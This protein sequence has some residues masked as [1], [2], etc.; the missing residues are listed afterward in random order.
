LQRLLDNLSPLL[1]RTMTPRRPLNGH[2]FHLSVPSRSHLPQVPKGCFKGERFWTWRERRC[3]P[4]AYQ[5]IATIQFLNHP[6]RLRLRSFADA[7]S[8]RSP[9]SP[10][11]P[12]PPRIPSGASPLKEPRGVDSGRDPVGRNPTGEGH[13][14]LSRTF[15]TCTCGPST[16]NAAPGN[17]SC[18][19]CP[20]ERLRAPG[21]YHLRSS[22]SLVRTRTGEPVQSA[23]GYRTA[24]V[25]PAPAVRSLDHRATAPGTRAS[26]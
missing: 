8:D 16:R 10:R 2:D 4:D 21:A 18:T 14:R 19:V 6:S 1:L 26:G 7:V 22:E 13:S 20:C 24:W 23:H 25:A 5:T 3:L 15:M 17:K 11:R 12:L 9:P